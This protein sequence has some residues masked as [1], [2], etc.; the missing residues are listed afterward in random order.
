MELAYA[1][2]VLGHV[3]MHILLVNAVLLEQ[4]SLDHLVTIQ[5]QLHTLVLQAVLCLDLPVLCQAH[6]IVHK[7]VLCLEA[8]VQYQLLVVTAV[9]VV[10][11]YQVAYV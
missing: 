2:S 1:I 6:T 10:E 3:L 7:V 5:Q 11:A 4:R 8:H 9:Q